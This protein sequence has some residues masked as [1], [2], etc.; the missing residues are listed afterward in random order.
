MGSKLARGTGV[1]TDGRQPLI[2]DIVAEWYNSVLSPRQHFLN[3][4]NERFNTAVESIRI[5]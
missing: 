5:L 4:W 3:G 1:V 2:Y